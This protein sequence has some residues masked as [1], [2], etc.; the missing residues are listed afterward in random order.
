VP[1]NDPARGDDATTV[2]AAAP[3]PTGPAEVAP[4][5]DTRDLGAEVAD[6]LRAQVG[7]TVLLVGGDQE[8]VARVRDGLPEGYELVTTTA[9]EA[10]IAAARL[11]APDA[12][13][14]ASGP[15]SLEA[16]AA[17]GDDPL[18]GGIP[19]IVLV[20]E[21]L[22]VE[23]SA[24]P[25]TLVDEPVRLPVDAS[26]L[27]CRI[28]EAVEGAGPGDRLLPGVGAFGQTTLGEL[29]DLV[30]GELEHL[31]LDV[32]GAGS[33]EVALTLD[34][35]GGELM[36]A[37]QDFVTRLRALATEGSGGRLSFEA[38]DDSRTSLLALAG[39]G[40]E[41][42]L[43]PRDDPAG[44]RLTAEEAE[45]FRGLR[46][47]AADDDGEVRDFFTTVLRDA[48]LEVEAVSNG[49]EALEAIRRARPDVVITDILMPEVDGW[50]LL[51]RLRRDLLLRD[52]PVL[53]LSWKEDFIERM[54]ELGAGADDYLRK[55]VAPRQLLLRLSGVLTA[56]RHVAAQ[57]AAEAEFAGRV[58]ALG[59]VPLLHLVAARGADRRLVVREAWNYFEADFRAGR[60]V[61][62]TCTTSSGRLIK[63]LD[64]LALL[65]G[66]ARG[67]FTVSHHTPTG[68]TNLSGELDDLLRRAAGPVQEMVETVSGGGLV[69]VGRVRLR[70]EALN[71]YEQIA[72]TEVRRVIEGLSWGEAPAA[73]ILSGAYSPLELERIVLD[74]IRRGLVEQV[75]RATP[76]KGA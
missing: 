64:A 19:V 69:R 54:R 15:G 31:M 40:G 38:L 26:E 37:L 50:E 75:E 36:A 51:R 33:R 76:S 53:V 30:E 28:A 68:R 6:G 71:E 10:G 44:A 49:Q 45:W 29:V 8:L 21:G 73:M 63:G 2:E 4:P 41:A 12:I 22:E 3:E 17:I 18:T 62:V 39:D 24:L 32:A 5:D 59:V 7:S 60:P 58:D 61:G 48:G 34:D 67:R 72:P 52:I 42:R 74:L 25:R 20:P 16:L 1:E 9:D 65:L 56:R 35:G 23:T 70:E 55:D 27:R 43:A 57:L 66:V 11:A 13:L 47:V 46:V 14:C